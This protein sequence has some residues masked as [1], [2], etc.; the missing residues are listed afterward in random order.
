MMATLTL[1]NR[2][3]PTAPTR[4]IPRDPRPVTPPIRPSLENPD[5][6]AARSRRVAIGIGPPKAPPQVAAAASPKA[7]PAPPPARAPRD[8]HN[9][10]DWTESERKRRS[11]VLDGLAVVASGKDTDQC[12]VAWAEARGL[13][14]WIDRRSSDAIGENGLWGNPFLVSD[15]G[16]EGCEERFAAVIESSA[17]LKAKIVAELAGKV[18][19][20]W[21]YPKRCHGDHLA[22]LANKAPPPTSAA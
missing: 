19:V 21:C 6:A 15:H 2:G 22:K 8:W 13:A 9:E 10:A 12:L 3:A 18:L 5:S 4:P 20:C 17:Y 7:P 14:V 16:R 11:A 1:K